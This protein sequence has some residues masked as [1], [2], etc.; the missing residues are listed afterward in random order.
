MDL[1]LGRED[2]SFQ[3]EVRQFLCEVL[4]EDLK[5][6]ARKTAGLHGDFESGRRWHRILHT[7]GWSAPTWPKEYGGPGWTAMQRY[8][9]SKE[10][11]LAGAPKIFGMG[12]RM[13]GP[14][15]MRFGSPEQKAHYLPRILS[16][17]D[18]WCQGYSEPGSGSDL[19]SLKTQAKLDGD[20]YVLNGTKIWTTY[21]HHATSMFCL[22]R[23][24]NEGKPQEGI[25]F[26][27]IDNIK[28]PEVT[29]R[30]LITLAG[31]HEVNQVF[32]DNVCVPKKNVIGPVN[33]GWTVAKYL[34]EFER[35]GDAYAPALYTRLEG[36][37]KIA[38]EEH[39]GSGKLIDDTGFRRKL[40]EAEIDVRC[41]EMM[42][43]QV[44]SDLTRGKSPGVMSS[45]LKI[46]RSETMQKI[47]ELGVEALGHYAAPFEPEA[48]MMGH[49]EPTVTPDYGPS[50]GCRCG[51]TGHG[52]RRCR[53][54]PAPARDRPGGT[55]SIARR[56]RSD[57]VGAAAAHA[58]RRV[59]PPGRAA[60][61][62]SRPVDRGAAR[63]GATARR[64]H[65]GA[66]GRRARGRRGRS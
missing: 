9:F 16:A 50:R 25:S 42:E 13:V 51:A 57:R 53:T 37:R 8:I 66:P 59:A 45:V 28:I 41:L 15:L 24:S 6:A 65:R 22:V 44:L 48:L 38:R 14:V 1:Q 19:A 52:C 49:N 27:L 4:T 33:Q 46:R 11:Q 47:D 39:A 12:V 2:L 5:E 32:L 64:A 63:C 60:R 43:L 23:T 34:L 10:L 26:I 17:D 54:P 3:Q 58:G 55:R 31:D 7:R 40:P 18:V 36:V 21:A 20:H 61:Q 62:P 56:G 35:G 29:V 30:P